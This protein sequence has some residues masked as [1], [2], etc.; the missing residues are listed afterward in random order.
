MS[1]AE[2]HIPALDGI[3]GLA[4][5]LVVFY[6]TGGGAKSSHL[7]LRT[8]GTVNKYGWSGVT[9]FFVLSGFLITGILWDTRED[10]HHLKN[11]YARR[12]LRIFPLY[13][14][15]LA[16]VFLGSIPYGA[17]HE[18]LSRIWVYV[19]Y[20]QNVDAFGLHPHALPST[21]ITV[22]FWSLAVEEQFYLLWPALLLRM[23]TLKQAQNLC[24]AVIV[25]S[26]VA[27]VV[28]AFTSNPLPHGESLWANSVSLALGGF[29][30]LGLRRGQNF[31]SLARYLMPVTFVVFILGTLG[32]NRVRTIFDLNALTLFWGCLIVI[33]L[34]PGLFKRMFEVGWLRWIGTISYGMYIYHWLFREYFD[35][36]TWKIYPHASES[37]HQG[38]RFVITF[39]LTIGIS[40]SSFNYFERPISRLKRHF[41]S[42]TEAKIAIGV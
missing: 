19:L 22:H 8:I 20:L 5:L 7:A 42:K 25:L 34:R 26:A 30:A 21:L 36:F 24:L 41:Q 1:H 15:A 35:S 37:T 4:V 2:K 18:C 3:R 38:I 33:S 31:Q 16:L 10:P 6:H 23:K 14:F 13:Y 32:S 39:I 28:Y 11:F 9:L 12:S 27:Q 40:W 17:F 29:I